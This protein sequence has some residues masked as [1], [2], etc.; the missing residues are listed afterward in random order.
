MTATIDMTNEQLVK[1]YQE[2]KSKTEKSDILGILFRKN[3][4][5]IVTI[6]KR[7]S[8]ATNE[9]IDDLVQE[10][11][12]GLAEAVKRFDFE[13]GVNFSTYAPHW[14]RQSMRRYIDECGTVR[15]PTYRNDNIYRLNQIIN[16]YQMEYGKE[17][18]DAEICTLLGIDLAQLDRI[19]KDKLR[20]RVRSLDETLP[21]TD[22]E[23]TLGDV[24]ADDHDQYDDILTISYNESL[25]RLLW[26]EVDTVLNDKE[27]AV[28]RR[29]FVDNMTMQECGSDM[30]MTA[31]GVRLHQASAMRKLRRCKALELYRDDVLTRAYS[32]T[33]LTSFLITNTSSTEKVALQLYEKQLD[34]DI[35][36]IEKKHGITLDERFRQERI[37]EYREKMLISV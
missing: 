6:A 20:L 30:E 26:H 2:T 19:R 33:G 36:K 27:Q 4:G 9:A 21:G 22:A 31:E 14:L 37:A 3:H 1:L 15:I 18:T 5:L 11:F 25:S 28:I 13:Q 8:I 12:F 23:V 10:S 16:N 32:G 35:K 7:Y 29:R 24:V 17:P 34:R